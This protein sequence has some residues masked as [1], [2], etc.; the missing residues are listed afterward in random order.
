MNK[1]L[2]RFY[3]KEI[4]KKIRRIKSINEKIEVLK[5]EKSILAIEIE[6]MDLDFYKKCWNEKG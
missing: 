1:E 6:E 2:E 4:S 3:R 5:K